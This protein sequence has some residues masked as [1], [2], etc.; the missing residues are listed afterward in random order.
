MLGT[1]NLD[2]RGE[3]KPKWRVR[4]VA[5]D[6]T[7]NTGLGGCLAERRALWFTFEHG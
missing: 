4:N 7:E 2:Q 5:C 3:L 6:H 1:V